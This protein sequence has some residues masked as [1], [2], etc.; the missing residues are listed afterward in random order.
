MRGP[1]DHY[2]ILGVKRGASAQEVRAAF[3]RAAKKAHPDQGGSSDAFR[4]LRVA[5]DL[6]LAEIEARG[7]A[8]LDGAYRAGDRTTA[9][10]DWTEVSDALRVKWG[11]GFE[12]II[13][14]PPSK[15]GLSPFATATSLNAPAF[16]WLIR[17]VGPRGEAWDFHIA[18]SQARIFFRRADDA[19]LFKLR[20]H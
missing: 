15:I 2:E 19:R 12:P 3:R 10:G 13:V 20:F 14:F 7:I 8:A 1:D 18:G 9:E 6:L 11:L 4:R 16:Q 5:A 17:M